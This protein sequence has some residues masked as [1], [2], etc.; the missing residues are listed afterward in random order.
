VQNVAALYRAKIATLGQK[1]G[2]GIKE[3]SA[4][5]SEV[6]RRNGGRSAV[7]WAVL[8]KVLQEQYGT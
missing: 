8:E 4:A 2:V 7:D 5:T 6:K 1:Y 3:I